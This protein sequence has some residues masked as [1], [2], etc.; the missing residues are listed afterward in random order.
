MGE[1]DYRKNVEI[2]GTGRELKSTKEVETRGVSPQMS[3]GG[4]SRGRTTRVEEDR[5]GVTVEGTGPRV[6]V[7]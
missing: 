6:G 2:R 1:Q 5:V 3:P 4:D 7:V